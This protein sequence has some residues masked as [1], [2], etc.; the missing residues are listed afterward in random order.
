MTHDNVSNVLITIYRAHHLPVFH[1]GYFS[2][3]V[4][5]RRAEAPW[6]NCDA[7]HR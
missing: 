7:F 3:M 6:E 2:H 4:E 5:K 1:L